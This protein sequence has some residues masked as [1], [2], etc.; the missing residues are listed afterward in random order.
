M[1]PA[2]KSYFGKDIIVNDSVM[3]KDVFNIADDYLIRYVHKD[4]IIPDTLIV[5]ATDT[6]PAS[7]SFL[8]NNITPDTIFVVQK[9]N[10]QSFMIPYTPTLNL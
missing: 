9:I 2:W 10:Q 8:Y 4:T 1:S 5:F 3:L 6:V 7:Y